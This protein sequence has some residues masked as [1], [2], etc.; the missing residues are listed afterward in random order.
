MERLANGGVPFCGVLA[1]IQNSCSRVAK[2]SGIAIAAGTS[3]KKLKLFFA[4]Q[5]LNKNGVKVE[6]QPSH[7]AK[8]QLAFVSSIGGDSDFVQCFQCFGC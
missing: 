8:N 4:L 6:S 2:N 5:T 7:P 1:R 3:D